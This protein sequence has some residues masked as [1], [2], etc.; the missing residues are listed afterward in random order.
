M[1]CMFHGPTWLAMYTSQSYSL[2]Y[3]KYCTVTSI[4]FGFANTTR[5]KQHVTVDNVNDALTAERISTHDHNPHINLA[6]S[7][8]LPKG[9]YILRRV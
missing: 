7:A 5:P 2:N 1:A 4:A 9:L 3:I 6:H 8:C